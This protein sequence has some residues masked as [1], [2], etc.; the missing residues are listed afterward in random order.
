M[1]FTEYGFFIMERVISKYRFGITL[2]LLPSVYRMTY[3]SGTELF[4]FQTL[5]SF[6]WQFV[7]SV[8]QVPT[9]LFNNSYKTDE[10]DFPEKENAFI[11]F[12]GQTSGECREI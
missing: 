10:S 12:Y 2:K 1:K 9:F 5:C 4:Q 11:D 8:G 7:N 3:D 6:A